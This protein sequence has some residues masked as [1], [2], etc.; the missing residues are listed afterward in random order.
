MSK[1]GG[2]STVMY[3][4]LAKIIGAVQFGLIHLRRPFSLGPDSLGLPGA[5]AWVGHPA[6]RPYWTSAAPSSPAVLVSRS[7]ITSTC[8]TPGYMLLFPN[9]TS[10]RNRRAGQDS[11]DMI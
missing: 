6:G 10:F 9:G 3:F 8:G 7:G 5:G 1:G 11:E 4:K 2:T